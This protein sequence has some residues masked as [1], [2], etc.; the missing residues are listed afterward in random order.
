MV[1]NNKPNISDNGLTV[2]LLAMDNSFKVSI[3]PD[4][5]VNSMDY[6]VEN[7]R[8]YYR[9]GKQHLH[10]WTKRNVPDWLK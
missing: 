10:K 6:A 5:F 4:E 9:N 7:Y 8:N 2:P 3:D 1:K